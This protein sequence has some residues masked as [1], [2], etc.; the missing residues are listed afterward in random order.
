MERLDIHMVPCRIQFGN[1]GYLDKVS[2]TA[3]E[4]FGELETNPH[5]PTTSQ[6][7][8][9]DFRRQF[10]FLASHFRDV[11]SINLTAAA[12]GTYEAAVSAADR[13]N[14][15]GSIHVLDSRNASLGQGLLAVFAAECAHAGL[16]IEKTLAATES[17]IP[18][19]RTIG[20]LDDM[21][22][23]VRGGRLPGWVRTI[24]TLL[25]VTPFIRTTED[26]RIAASG[27]AFG[28]RN[29]TNKFARHVVRHAR[30]AGPIC[31]AIGHAACP[32]A[33]RE[34]ERQLRKALP[35][36]KRL[37]MTELGAGLGAHAGPGTL[38][39]AMQPFT[40]PVDVS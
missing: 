25:H 18:Q 17:L 24:A 30:N 37:T 8:P 7:S 34:L 38:A 5:H 21:K 1:H 36:I 28:K 12:S 26:G 23:A 16:S 19:T 29:R 35:N 3:D 10:Q 20:V 31:L 39:I 32:G 40:R 15:P 6:P 11:L 27:F 4:F 33:A 2:I 14:A 13:T 9:G 22:Y